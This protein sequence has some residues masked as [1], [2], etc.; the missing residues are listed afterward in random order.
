MI[1]CRPAAVAGRS[2]L[3][4]IAVQRLLFAIVAALA[5]VCSAVAQEAAKP[6]VF[7]PALYPPEI[8]AALQFARDACKDAEGGEVTFAPG[9]VRKLDLT[10]DRRPDYIVNFHE[11]ECERAKAVYCGTGGCDFEIFVTLPNGKL[12]SVYGGRV[13]QYDLLPG[14]GA[15]RIRFWLH[16]SYC[17][18]SGS[19]SCPKTRRITSR[20]FEF[21]EPQ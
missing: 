17:G 19:P 20:P 7:N 12:R 2:M 9:T 14:R 6:P 15:R 1:M 8:Q 16:G 21:K 11:T 4:A 18:R 5:L 10:G 13:R 3:E